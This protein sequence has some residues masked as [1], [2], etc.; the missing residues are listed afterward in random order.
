M[1]PGV[2]YS[3]VSEIAWFAFSASSVS[4][5]THDSFPSEKSDLEGQTVYGDAFRSAGEYDQQEKL[6]AP[7]RPPWHNLPRGSLTVSVGSFTPAWAKQYNIGLT[8]GLHNPF[9]KSA[10]E[11]STDH[12]TLNVP[13]DP[14]QRPARV[15]TKP[16]HEG[17]LHESDDD[18]FASPTKHNTVTIDVPDDYN[19]KK[20]SLHPLSG[21]SNL[22]RW[23][24]GTT[25][26]GIDGQDPDTPKRG[27]GMLMLR[28]PSERT[29]N[30]TTTSATAVPLSPLGR[31]SV[32]SLFPH[33]VREEDWNLPLTK[34]P[35]RNGRGEG[36]TTA[37]ATQDITPAGRGRG[38]R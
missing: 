35:F 11:E 33:D 8:R 7:A 5:I 31:K 15:I 36:W 20:L 21:F 1:V 18:P 13:S 22:L 25:S 14:V 37:D 12:Q 28:N 32:S 17:R 9:G 23:S 26:G 38:R 4:R 2:W 6:K 24:A 27:I 29:S 19:D 16:I 10:D 30:T 3:N 34:P